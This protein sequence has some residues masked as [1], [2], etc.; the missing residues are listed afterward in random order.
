MWSMDGV[1]QAS[2]LKAVPVVSDVPGAWSSSALS[3]YVYDCG[4]LFYLGEVILSRL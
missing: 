4:K 2:W 1:S 3:G